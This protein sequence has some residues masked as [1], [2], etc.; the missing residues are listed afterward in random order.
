MESRSLKFDGRNMK[1]QIVVHKL[2]ESGEEMMSYQGRI[3]ESTG[4]SVTLEAHFDR[5][6][7]DLAGITLVRGDRFRETFYS[8]RWYNTF[9]IYSADGEQFKGWYCNITR[10][11]KIRDGHVHAEDLALDLVVLPDGEWLVLDEDEF[12]L[13]DLPIDDRLRARRA[14]E[15]LINHARQQTGPFAALSQDD[16]L[17]HGEIQT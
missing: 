6:R 4:N 13:M 16:N 12:D 1:E 3:I 17:K 8:D 10:P 11:A 2:N 7:V 14:L 9:A 15:A 5:E